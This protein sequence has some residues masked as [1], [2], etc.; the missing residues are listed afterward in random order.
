MVGGPVG[1]MRSWMLLGWVARPTVLGVVGRAGSGR[2]RGR[3]DRRT[4]AG[5]R[6]SKRSS[7]LAAVAGAG[8]VG[9][10]GA[11]VGAS[12]RRSPV[13]RAGALYAIS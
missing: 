5:Y 3:S 1:C 2:A 4:V 10:T 12:A 6:S 8:A 11:G 9:G 7:L 13:S